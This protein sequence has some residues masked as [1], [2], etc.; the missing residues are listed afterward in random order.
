MKVI[1]RLLTVNHQYTAEVSENRTNVLI[2]TRDKT[3]PLPYG[4]ND[5]DMESL[6]QSQCH[7]SLGTEGQLYLLT[8]DDQPLI[9]IVISRQLFAIDPMLS[10][11]SLLEINTSK[12]LGDGGYVITDIKDTDVFNAGFF[13]IYSGVLKPTNPE[14]LYGKTLR[15][16]SEL[17]MAADYDDYLEYTGKHS[18]FTD[19]ILFNNTSE[20][21]HLNTVYRTASVITNLLYV[22]PDTVHEWLYPTTDG[23]LWIAPKQKGLDQHIVDSKQYDLET[24]Q[25][26]NINWIMPATDTNYGKVHLEDYGDYAAVIIDSRELKSQLLATGYEST[27]IVGPGYEAI[28]CPHYKSAN[29]LFVRAVNNDLRSPVSDPLDELSDTDFSDMDH[30]F[31]VEDMAILAAEDALPQIVIPEVESLPEVTP[32]TPTADKRIYEMQRSH[33]PVEYLR[34]SHM[35]NLPG[36]WYLLSLPG[37]YANVVWSRVD[38]S[39]IHVPDLTTGVMVTYANVTYI[40]VGDGL[41]LM[42]DMHINLDCIQPP[43][44]EVT[45]LDL[46]ARGVAPVD[47]MAAV[48]ELLH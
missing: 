44:L 20:V 16:V 11:Q 41:V 33:V 38:K 4:T 26:T 5:I 47:I 19:L 2:S 27:L 9:A 14:D 1:S 46:V 32:S 13:W 30:P 21:I 45:I 36:E 15:A 12:N 39:N 34:Y 35:P 43:D 3:F 22:F 10:L 31:D 7:V 18:P 23:E 25:P 6:D 48:V 29:W 37:I 17:G 40:N 28:H 42:C 8:K 24:V